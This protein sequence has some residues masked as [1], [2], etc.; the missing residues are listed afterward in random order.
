ML[1]PVPPGSAENV[2]LATQSGD[3]LSV[4]KS[5]V[6]AITT[7]KSR[8][9]PSTEI[10]RE[11]KELQEFPPFRGVG[12][13]PALLVCLPPCC[14]WALCLMH[15]CNCSLCTCLAFAVSCIYCMLK[16]C[17]FCGKL[18]LGFPDIWSSIPS[19]LLSGQY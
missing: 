12:E 10:L 16:C 18:L 19:P 14:Q 2:H 4:S 13:G 6:H 8:E 11:R 17:A 7:A 15:C 1:Q 3:L 5:T 9:Y